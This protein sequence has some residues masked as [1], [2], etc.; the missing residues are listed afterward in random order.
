MGYKTILVHV[1]ASAHAQ[2]AIAYAGRLAA[3][4]G[5]HLVGLAGTGINELVYQCNAAAPGVY[6]QPQDLA[7]L[8]DL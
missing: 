2:P 8:R 6:L 7:A 4:Q 3:Q 1:D 5:A